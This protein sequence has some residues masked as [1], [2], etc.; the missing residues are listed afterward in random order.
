MGTPIG[1]W[2][3]DNLRLGIRFGRMS[4]F[5]LIGTGYVVGKVK[6]LILSE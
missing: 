2:V 5:N 6:I 1:G 3:Q 4:N